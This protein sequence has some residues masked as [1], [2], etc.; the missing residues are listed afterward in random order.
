MSSPSPYAALDGVSPRSQRFDG[1]DSGSSYNPSNSPAA[2]S[3]YPRSYTNNNAPSSSAS[4]PTPTSATQTPSSATESS[5]YM[6]QF[7]IQLPGA[8]PS[9]NP[10]ARTGASAYQYG[11][12]SGVRA[13]VAC[14]ACRKR[15]VKC[16]AVVHPLPLPHTSNQEPP[17]RMCVRCSRLGIECSWKDEKKGGNKQSRSLK[18]PTSAQGLEVVFETYPN[19][20]QPTLSIGYALAPP[21]FSWIIDM[22]RLLS[23]SSDSLYALFSDA[24][25]E[26]G[27]GAF[28]L[29]SCSNTLS[30]HQL[31]SNNNS[32]QHP[33]SRS[34]N[35]PS[36]SAGSTSQS[37]RGSISHSHPPS[38][39]NGSSRGTTASSPATSPT[40]ST[41]RSSFSNQYFAVSGSYPSHMFATCRISIVSRVGRVSIISRR[42]PG[43]V[44]MISGL[45]AAL[46]RKIVVDNP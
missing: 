46:R 28:L 3:P 32:S 22:H 7:Q 23:R 33:S 15:K 13:S 2:S 40:S 26:P 45:A 4:T 21:D 30:C 19:Q 8:P 34:P 36:T 6:Q 29:W 17:P 1:P 42:V 44:S 18:S 20:P 10:A 9:Q 5:S 24:F 31:F 38:S 25:L 27:A 14:D 11:G 16:T 41:S 39:Y 43:R 37:E 12:P 35:S